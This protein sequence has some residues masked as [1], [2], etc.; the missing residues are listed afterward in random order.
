MMIRLPL[1]LGCLFWANAHAAD[2]PQAAGPDGNFIT[3]G[4]APTE[5]SGA[6]G[7]G[8]KW[9]VPLPSTGQGTPIVSGD[10]IFVTSHEPIKADTEFGAGILGLC[11]DVKT[12][13][14]LW[15]RAIPGTRTT[16]LSSLFN[17]NTAATPVADG[18][19]VVFTNVGGTIKCFDYDGNELWSHTWTP[20]GRHHARAHEPILHNGNVILMH[21]A[22]YDLPVEATTKAGSKKYGRE[23]PYW[24][25]LRAY[26]LATGKLAWQA[27]AGTSVHAKSMLGKLPDGR[28]VILTGRGGGHQ[29]PEEPYGMSLVDAANGKSIWDAPVEKFPTHQNFVFKKDAAYGFTGSHHFALDLRKGKPQAKHPLAAGVTVTRWKEGRYVTEMDQA[30][31][32]GKKATT[33]FTNL[34]VGDFHY[35]R[36]HSGFLIGRVQLSTGK[37]EYLQVPAQVIRHKKRAAELLWDKALPNDMKTA[38]GFRATQDKR[39]AGNGWGHVSAAPPTVVGKHIYWPTMIGTVYVVDWTAPRLN[40]KA[41]VSLSDLGSAG[42]TWS[43]ASLA[44]ADGRLYARTLKELICFQTA[45]DAK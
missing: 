44:Y 28:S 39:N 12:G 10:R 3:Q 7:K 37:V 15:R 9:R 5:F 23:K 16:D 13:K 11:F 17:D 26:D 41:L 38:N 20:F 2:W 24:T 6:T 32:L 18:K 40:E 33:Y 8:V 42:Q 22:T 31:K 14:E 43:L 36:A 4:E 34:I 35:F 21:A 29:P 19:R 30:I 25:H 1:L 27:E 45:K